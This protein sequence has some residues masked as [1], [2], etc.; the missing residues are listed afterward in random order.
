MSTFALVACAFGKKSLK[1]HLMLTYLWIPGINSVLMHYL[2]YI[3]PNFILLLFW[4]ISLHL[5]LWMKPFLVSTLAHTMELFSNL[6]SCILWKNLHEIGTICSLRVCRIFLESH[7]GLVLSLNE[8]I[9]KFIKDFR[10]TINK[11]G[12]LENIH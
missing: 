10:E 4:L 8:W 12:S 2:L 3:L 11:P 7:L 5:Y 1:K 6:S 9:Y